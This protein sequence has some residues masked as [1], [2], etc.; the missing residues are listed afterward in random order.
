MFEDRLNIEPMTP[1]VEQRVKAVE[2]ARERKSGVRMEVH[3]GHTEFWADRTVPVG[4]VS[5]C[6]A[7]EYG[8]W[9]QYETTL[10]HPDDEWSIW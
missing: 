1:D 8:G 6:V 9:P 4:R 3:S 5:V 10:E 2:L 7:R